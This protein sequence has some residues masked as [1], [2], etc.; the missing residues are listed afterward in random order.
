[1]L[2]ESLQSFRAGEIRPVAS[3]GPIGEQLFDE[4]SII[5]ITQNIRQ[6]QGSRWCG[7]CVILNSIVC[8]HMKLNC[9]DISENFDETL[10]E[11]RLPQC[12]GWK[13]ED[14]QIAATTMM[15]S[16]KEGT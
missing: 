13:S 8:L 10:R 9:A 16:I 4:N 1:M 6:P 2:L 15:K 14:F 12:D 5:K 3:L 7:M 11:F